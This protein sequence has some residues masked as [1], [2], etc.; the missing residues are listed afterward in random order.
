MAW[1]DV[2]DRIRFKLCVQVFKNSMASGYLAEL[3][4]AD[5]SPA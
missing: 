2:A 3:C 5:M 4:R 1:L